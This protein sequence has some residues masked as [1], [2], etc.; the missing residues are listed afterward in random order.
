MDSTTNDIGINKRVR[1]I[2]MNK[3][4]QADE[5]K[6]LRKREM[7]YVKRKIRG[8]LFL[9][10]LCHPIC[11]AMMGVSWYFLYSLC[12]FGRLHKNLPILLACMAFWLCYFVLFLARS[13]FHNL[14][15]PL[16]VFETVRIEGGSF[17]CLYDEKECI[18]FLY[19]EIK[20]YHRTKKNSY[21]FLKGG[22]VILIRTVN[23]PEEERDFLKIKLSSRG[24]FHRF[25]WQIPVILLLIITGT[26]CFFVGKSAVHFNGKLSW[27]LEDLKDK[28]TAAIEHNNV[29]K[30]GI[31]GFM[32]DIRKKVNIPE[33]LSLATS[34]NMHF[35]PDGT[36]KTI[37]TMLYG[38]DKNGK[39]VNSYLITYNAKKADKIEIYL[40]GY[41]EDAAYDSNK[42]FS[43]L[44]EAVSVIP[45]EDTVSEWSEEE[46]GILYYGVR[47][48][49]IVDEGIVFVDENGN[50]KESEDRDTT[51]QG[52]S[53]SI[54][55]PNNDAIKPVRYLYEKSPNET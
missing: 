54:F 53:I 14:K 26:G 50:T 5:N 7:K 19:K 4:N 18:T 1:H 36:I 41:A 11:L 12:Q 43:M 55:C 2:K 8:Q 45:V 30:D 9:R 21:L 16:Y 33:K 24:I 37:D 48:W 22:R 32:E 3:L 29:Y 49:T 47:Q 51:V 15:S 39:F 27:L 28:R 17:I 34:F 40:N 42:D 23:M 35:L 38:Y 10:M 44:E 46:Y 25:Y 31:K 20:K 13:I 52:Y 6:K